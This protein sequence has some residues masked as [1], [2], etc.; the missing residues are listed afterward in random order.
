[1]STRANIVIKDKQD[2]LFFYRHSD[3]YPGGAMPILKHFMDWLRDGKIRGNVG[4]S[5]GWLVILGA[6]EYASIPTYS[7]EPTKYTR[8]YGD[9]NSINS[10]VDWK[11][12]AIEP[13]IG[14]HGDI[15]YLY[16]IDVDTKTLECHGNW[17]DSGIGCNLILSY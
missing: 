4:Q 10:P 2:K 1:M 11:C 5:A 16:V 14:I 3:G 13:T 12:G 17:Y 15:E 7:L 9:V 6:M 8:S